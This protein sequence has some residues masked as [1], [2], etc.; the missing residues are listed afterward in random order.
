MGIS[1]KPE[2]LARYRDIARL[3]WKYGRSDL[4]RRAGLDHELELEPG[5]GPADGTTPDAE[6]LAAEL[7]AL[8]P[9]FI[10][11]G[12][13]LSTRADLLPLPYI[14]AL[15]RLQ[16]KVEPFA[17]EEVES[18]VS[19]A[20]GVRLSKAFLEFDR[21]PLAAASLGQV[22]RAV[23]R[24]GRMVAV[25]VQRPGI[26][27]VI[28]DD[29]EAL[30]E[31]AEL[32]DRHSDAAENFDL[33]G[34]LDEFRRTL[35]QELDYRRE[36]SHLTILGRNLQDFPRILVPRPVADYTTDRV[37]TMEYVRGRKITALSPLARLELDGGALADELFRAYLT[38]ILVDGFFHADPHPGNVFLTPDGAI[39]LLDLGMVAHVSPA[40]QDV[41][42]RLVLAISEGR[43]DEAADAALQ[44]GG[45]RPDFDETGFRRGVAELVS[46]H[47]HS[48]A[49]EIQIGQVVLEV[50]R[51]GGDNGV[52]VPPE[53]TL[54]GKT[55]LNLDQVGRT[56]DPDFDPNAAVRRDAAEILR[57]RALKAAS[58]GNLLS[59]AVELNEFVQHLP[60]R[61]NRV[62]DTVAANE[63]ELR[64]KASLDEKS[65]IAGLQKIANRIA[66]GLVLAAFILG[67]ALLMHV[68]TA[69]TIL[70]YPGLAMIFF[71]VAVVGAGA[72]IV[73]IL[74]HDEEDA[75]D[76]GGR[77]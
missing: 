31:L 48:T 15:A 25:K 65:L 52:G 7:E 63:L 64:V 5:P 24:S 39:A 2:H 68:P 11:L 26:R 60:A 70:G 8:G 33:P 40:L 13:L 55:L 51:I 72:L 61:L 67:A 54:L 21:A 43:G 17:F 10:K 34:M 73:D 66:A 41:L 44:L 53:I 37:L 75:G 22:H 62:L 76:G 12:Q 1:L 16:D 14:E 30:E 27:Q 47:R 29:L 9:T 19:E 50:A 49:A 74:L 46:R 36:A 32:A 20:L 23:L 58:P 4:V 45:A 38:Q 57:R 28:L 42:L 18:T 59:S 71:L 35:L 56:L 77:G 3:L 69:F 6:A